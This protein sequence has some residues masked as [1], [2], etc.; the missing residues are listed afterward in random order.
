MKKVNYIFLISALLIQLKNSAQLSI[1]KNGSK[2]TVKLASG[3]DFPKQ[4][5]TIIGINSDLQI[6]MAC[7]KL[8]TQSVNKF[9]KSTITSY[10]CNYINANGAVLGIK[11]NKGDSVKEF[12]LNKNSFIELLNT[13][14]LLIVAYK[15]NKYLAN[16]QFKQ[17][18]FGTYN[19][20]KPTA[21]Y[22]RIIVET[23][24]E[25]G[26][27]L[28]GLINEKEKWMIEPNY[29]DIR[30]NEKDSLFYACTSGNIAGGDDEVFNFEAKKIM[31]FKRH[32]DFVNKN[33]VIHK[34]FVPN[35]YYIVYNLQSKEEKIVNCV[36]LKFYKN[37]DFIIQE[38]KGNYLWNFITN[39]KTNTP[40]QNETN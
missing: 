6:C 18:T 3:G 38:K 17:L 31:A 9:I 33:Y 36:N 40:L 1:I 25:S 24:T 2:Y 29:S 28:T 15:S 13:K 37:D 21:F 20:I 8:T 22:N 34:I 12:S 4:F 14:D 16:N 35:E 23:K 26:A 10:A 19:G 39:Q 5:D 27:Y 7:Q 30:V 11:D 32:I